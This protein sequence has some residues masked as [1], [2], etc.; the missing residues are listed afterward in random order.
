MLLYQYGQYMPNKLLQYAQSDKIFAS[1]LISIY[2]T[3]ESL[4]VFLQ[5]NKDI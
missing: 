2:V 4:R 1:V 5:V 3:L